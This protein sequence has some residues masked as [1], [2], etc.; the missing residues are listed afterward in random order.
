MV[1]GEKPIIIGLLN[2]GRPGAKQQ[3][4]ENL[5]VVTRTARNSSE[6]SFKSQPTVL[7]K[8]GYIGQM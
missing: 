4:R 3:Q 2:Q 7:N 1:I 6:I 5:Y 8:E